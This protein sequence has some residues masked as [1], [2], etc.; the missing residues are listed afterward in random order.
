MSSSSF[1]VSTVK[2]GDQNYLGNYIRY[3]A[4]GRTGVNCL[5]GTKTLVQVDGPVREN[6][7]LLGSPCF[8]IPRAVNRDVEM[9]RMD[10][11]TRRQRL[12]AKN[13]YNFV[14]AALFL[15]KTWFLY[16][17][18][19]LA[20]LLAA[21]Y[22]PRYGM[23]AAF[24]WAAFAFFFA[25]LWGWFVERASLGF[26][27]LKP[28]I[29]LALDPYYW[30]HE[31]HWHMF[32]LTQIASAFTGT[33]FKNLISRLEGVRMG[34]KV[35]DDGV[36]WTEYSLIEIGDYTNLNAHSVIW[37]HSLEEGV[38]KS[39]YIK[40]GACCTLGS[41]SLTHYG[42]IMG[43]HVVLEPDSYLM[44]GELLDPHTT[45]RGNPAK[46]DVERTAPGVERAPPVAIAPAEVS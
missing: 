40:I 3:P 18:L 10:D 45:W 25:M 35:F 38:F 24:G 42:V 20:A 41:G 1:K 16:F 23:L 22:H 36:R 11:T 34:K 13:R 6:V 19:T 37:P 8:E 46:A 30:F 14:T 21:A 12:R 2:I 17:V 32:G 26:G 15:L 9:S 7:G 29:E 44:K 28:Q 43:D 33:P 27:W 31:R 5:V 4:G 39:D